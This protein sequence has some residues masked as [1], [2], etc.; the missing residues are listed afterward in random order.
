MDIVDYL[1]G[2][3]QTCAK[4]FMEKTDK[5]MYYALVTAAK[6]DSYAR[7]QII[8]AYRLKRIKA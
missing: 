3:P 6:C 4:E 8:Q 1:Q 2:L 7:K 5:I